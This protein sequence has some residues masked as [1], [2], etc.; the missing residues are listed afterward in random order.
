MTTITIHDI[1]DEIEEKLKFNAMQHH[2]TV[3]EEVCQILKQALFNSEKSKKLASYLHQHVME[4]TEG[5][6]LDLPKRSLSR[7]APDFLE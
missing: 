7:P 3:E 6:E 5:V 2:C 4:L 1:D